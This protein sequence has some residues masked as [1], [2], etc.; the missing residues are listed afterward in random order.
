MVFFSSDF[1]LYGSVS[2]HAQWFLVGCWTLYILKIIDAS[3]NAISLQKGFTVFS[4]RYM[5]I[6]KCEEDNWTPSFQ[7]R[8]DLRLG[9]RF[10][11]VWSPFDFFLFPNHSY[12]W[13]SKE[14]LVCSQ[15][16]SLKLIL[17]PIFCFLYLD[18]LKILFRF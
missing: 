16:H 6:Q 11:K 7:S 2:W 9:C 8:N 15:D 17:K 13:P 1:W 14:S 12:S 18:I 3:G 5:E 4:V 10:G